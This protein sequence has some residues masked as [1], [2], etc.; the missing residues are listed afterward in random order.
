MPP[1]LT[2]PLLRTLPLV[3]LLLAGSVL[4]DGPLAALAPGSSF[5]AIHL[6][7]AGTT[8]PALAADVASLDGSAARDALLATLRALEADAASPQAHAADAAAALGAAI[9]LLE[10]G[11][12]GDA[13]ITRCPAL[14]DTSLPTL[15]EGLL[16]VS[17]TARTP[18][19][20]ALLLLRVD[21]NATGAATAVID[22]LSG[23]LGDGTVLHQDGVA[24]TPLASDGVTTTVAR[25]GD[26]I[27][28]G[29]ST[30][31][32]RAAVRL[33]NG[34]QEPSLASGPAGHSPALTGTGIGLTVDTTAVADVLDALPGVGQ[35]A[36]ARAARARLQ[37]ASR[38]VP[39]L[40]LRLSARSDGVLV[41]S[42]THVDASGGDPALAKLLLCANCRARPSLLVPASALAVE[43]SP[44]RLAAWSDYLTGMVGDVLRAGGSEL[45][46]LALL[47]QRSGID[48]AGDLFP[49]L[50]DT[51][52]TVALPAPAGTPPALMGVPAQVTIVP[53]ASAAR[54]RAGLTRLGTALQD[55]LDQL[56]ASRPSAGGVRPSAL[57]AS[58]TSSYRD[59]TVTRIQIGPSADL[60]IALVGDRLVL[61]SPSATLNTVIDTFRGGPTLH[62]GP[63]AAALATAP[64]DALAV[65]ASDAAAPLRGGAN[66]LRALSQPLAFAVQGALAGARQASGGTSAA[67]AGPDLVSLLRFTELPANALDAL[68]R[69][70]GIARGWTVVRDGTVETHLF[71]PVE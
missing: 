60:G 19:P 25:V 7:P 38:T 16:V 10:G 43:A 54:A 27:A 28:L 42:W 6:A 51:A 17:A 30:D 33:A 4:A 66:L 55:L 20:A 68:A 31:L 57:V 40:A 44:M 5:L 14:A 3:V 1:R 46:P 11:R 61:A 12:G 9:D 48:L 29:S 58:R 52:T 62:D 32:V 65:R 49:W 53:V 18:I 36:V 67:P 41:E 56:P 64:A 45:D 24:L 21:G 13:L 71:V 23:C 63:L 26:V 8:Y 50:G 22:V 59:V 2:R 69:H 15:R 35:D 34:S 39:L 37:A 47:K 70:L